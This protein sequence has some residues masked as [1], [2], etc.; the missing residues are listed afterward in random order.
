MFGVK[1]VISLNIWWIS[2]AS[3]QTDVGN[4][5]LIL[6]S[7]PKVLKEHICKRC[8]EWHQHAPNLY[9]PN[10]EICFTN[11]HLFQFLITLKLPISCRLPILPIY[12]RPPCNQRGESTN[13]E[14]RQII[15]SEI[16]PTSFIWSGTVML[17]YCKS[18]LYYQTL[19]GLC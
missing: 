7:D 6:I 10:Y 14:S 1:Q 18:F 2:L 12:I 17:R 5:I 9:H 15:L 16:F 3:L 19:F 11:I 8:N 13:Y 4:T